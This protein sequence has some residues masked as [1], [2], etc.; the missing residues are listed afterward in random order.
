MCI[1]FCNKENIHTK[2]CINY[3]LP[4]P[5][6]RDDPQSFNP[7]PREVTCSGKLPSDSGTNVFNPPVL[8]TNSFSALGDG[9]PLSSSALRVRCIQN[10]KCR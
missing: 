1:S 8:A 6:R 4:R 10:T 3:V 5:R 7:V 2:T 9:T